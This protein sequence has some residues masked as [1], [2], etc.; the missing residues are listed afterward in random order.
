MSDTR[1]ALLRQW[2]MLLLIPRHPRKTT[3]RDIRSRLAADGFDT[4]TRTIQRDLLELSGSRFPIEYDDRSKPYG[5]SWAKGSTPFHLPSLSVG[6][7]MVLQMVQKHLRGLLPESSL[8]T[9]DPYFR[10]AEK[11]IEAALGR[12]RHQW[13]D[14]VR[15]V[16]PTQPL[17]PPEVSPAARAEIYEAL[18]GGWQVQIKYL[19]RGKAKPAEYDV[20]PLAI[21]QR[22]PI[23]YLVATIFKYTDIRLLALHRIK[24][25]ARIEH[26]AKRPTD[27]DL[28][29][30]LSDGRLDFGN[31]KKIR[32]RLLFYGG[33]GDHLYE[34]PLSVDQR[35]EDR[36]AGTIEITATVPHTPQLEW[37]IEGFCAEVQVLEP[38]GMRARLI[39]RLKNAVALYR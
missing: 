5:W 30:Y 11:Q 9:L 24:S 38:E 3:V 29:S 16:P 32:L 13:L 18:L 2:H 26:K 35:I 33:A 22:G 6:D 17:I 14:L 12:K 1:N 34:S 19:A 15:V 28:D 7:A 25:A 21:V 36:G 20:N 10:A 39:D 27:F 4:T 8:E 37:W 31:G 23:T